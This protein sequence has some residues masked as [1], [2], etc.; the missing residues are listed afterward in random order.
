MGAAPGSRPARYRSSPHSATS[1]AHPR[2]TALRSFRRERRPD[3]YRLSFRLAHLLAHRDRHV[4]CL[5]D[6]FSTEEDVAN[7]IKVLTPFLD[8]YFPVPSPWEKT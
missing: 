5:N 8:T 6:A 4:F 1:G 3:D 7:Q 2:R